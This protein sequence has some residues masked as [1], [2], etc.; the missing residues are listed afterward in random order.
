[1]RGR[2]L[3]ILDAVRLDALVHPPADKI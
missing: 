3:K 2:Q 1:V